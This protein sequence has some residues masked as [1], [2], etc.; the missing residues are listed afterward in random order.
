VRSDRRAACAR[1]APL[2]PAH[3]SDFTDLDA[4]DF[5]DA[6][7]RRIFA[8]GLELLEAAERGEVGGHPW[9]GDLRPDRDTVRRMALLGLEDD[10]NAARRHAPLRT[11]VLVK[12]YHG[13]CGAI[14]EALERVP[15]PERLPQRDIDLVAALGRA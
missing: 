15:Y 9:P 14:F 5:S 2:G 13:R 10:R 12:Q 8:L 4:C 7:H 3:A 6:A 11:K 1:L